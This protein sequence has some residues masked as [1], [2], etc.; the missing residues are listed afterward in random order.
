MPPN[1]RSV[2]AARCRS[3]DLAHGS[4]FV[5]C[6]RSP[7]RTANRCI[8]SPI[9]TS[10]ALV[11]GRNSDSDAILES[12]FGGFGVGL[13]ARCTPIHAAHVLKRRRMSRHIESHRGFIPARVLAALRTSITVGCALR[14]SAGQRALRSEE[15]GSSS[16]PRLDAVEQC[17]QRSLVLLR[18]SIH[19]C[20]APCSQSTVACFRG[21]MGDAR[22]H[23]SS[24][25]TLTCELMI[26]AHS[27]MNGRSSATYHQGALEI[28]ED[29]RLFSDHSKPCTCVET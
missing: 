28:D 13:P 11:M 14:L 21:T 29:K 26:K 5:H 3:A 7:E 24:S 27:K 16:S 1:T 4:F 22:C 18:V 19:H 2:P 25:N 12:I 10:Y 23:R 8:P 20:R 6:A 17:M 9:P 15:R